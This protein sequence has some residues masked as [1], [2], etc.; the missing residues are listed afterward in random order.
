MIGT[1]LKTKEEGVAVF[2]RADDY[3]RLML[4]NIKGDILQRDDWKVLPL[5]ECSLNEQNKSITENH[6]D[7]TEKVR[8][9]FEDEVNKRELKRHL[10]DKLREQAI[11]RLDFIKRGKPPKFKERVEELVNKIQTAQMKTIDKKKMRSQLRKYGIDPEDLVSNLEKLIM[12]LPD[13]KKIEINRR[14]A[15]VVLSESLYKKK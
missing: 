3:F 11:N 12:S 15:Q 13:E 14:Y 5:L 4:A 9:L 6:Y 2:C 10:L 8:E 7:I 1:G